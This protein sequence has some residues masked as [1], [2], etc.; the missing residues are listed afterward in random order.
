MTGDDFREVLDALRLAREY[1]AKVH[2]SIAGAMGH[3]RTA[4]KPD[5]DKIDAAIRI[6][7][8]KP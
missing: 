1:V 5:L 2:G 8:S 7:E 4:V 6:L 3:E